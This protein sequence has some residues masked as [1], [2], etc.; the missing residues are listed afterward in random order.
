MQEQPMQSNQQQQ[1]SL[2]PASSDA[3]HAHN[4]ETLNLYEGESLSINI[5]FFLFKSTITVRQSD[6][7]IET[8]VCFSKE[9]FLSYSK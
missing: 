4:D 2:I 5:N 7:K 6:S 3:V 8:F 1:A 9:T